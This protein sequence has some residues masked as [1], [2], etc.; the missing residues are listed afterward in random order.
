[1]QSSIKLKGKSLCPRG[2]LPP[3]LF[4]EQTRQVS[5]SLARTKDHLVSKQEKL[6]ERKENGSPKQFK[7]D[8]CYLELGLD[9]RNW[10]ASENLT[11]V[12]VRGPYEGEM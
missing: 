1:M 9:S 3:L 6:G 2:D 4:I 10:K 7:Q 11:F 12:G 5:T 8:C